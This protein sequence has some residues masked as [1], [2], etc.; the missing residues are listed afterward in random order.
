[1]NLQKLS[2]RV[3]QAG[4]EALDSAYEFAGVETHAVSYATGATEIKYRARVYASSGMVAR[5]ESTCAK[6]LLHKLGI[7]LT[8]IQYSNSPQ[9]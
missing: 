5:A 2:Q 9:L 7:E 8:I 3:V 4:K 6:D 1:M